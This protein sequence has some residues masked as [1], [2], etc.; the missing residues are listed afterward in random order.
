MLFCVQF[1]FISS[2]KRAYVNVHIALYTIVHVCRLANVNRALTI[3]P[4]PNDDVPFGIQGTSTLCSFIVISRTKHSRT[5]LIRLICVE[6]II[7]FHEIK[8]KKRDDCVKTN[9]FQLTRRGILFH[10]N[11]RP[12]FQ[13]N[14][15]SNCFQFKSIRFDCSVFISIMQSSI[16]G[17]VCARSKIRM[18]GAFIFHRSQVEIV[19]SGRGFGN[20]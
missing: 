6:I 4:P 3:D 20:A 17:H 8:F 14:Y 7:K 13:E 18:L 12:I 19:C 10:W 11:E 2:Y 15:D 9:I 5:T 16:Q 1:I